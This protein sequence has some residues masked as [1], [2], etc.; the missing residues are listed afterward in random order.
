MEYN[1]NPSTGFSMLEIPIA[2]FITMVGMLGLYG[3]TLSL[4]NTNGVSR[5]LTIAS[6]LAQESLEDVK[7]VSYDAVVAD[8]FP[9]ED[10]G[11]IT[12]F[13]NFSRAVTIVDDTPDTGSKTILV[14]VSWMGDLDGSTKSMTLGTILGSP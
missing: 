11:S 6:E 9:A 12:G 14:V 1:K 10:F 7:S 4:V 13:A 5:N 3:M 8:A 2:L